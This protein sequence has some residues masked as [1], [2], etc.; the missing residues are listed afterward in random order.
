MQKKIDS[1]F[2]FARKSGSL[3]SGAGTCEVLAGKG[4]LKLLI[5]TEDT[6]EGSCRKMQRLARANNIPYRIYG[7][8]DHLSHV[9]GMSGR[10]VFAVTDQGFADVITK[11]I[12]AEQKY[13]KEVF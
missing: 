10:N 6:A 7:N 2:G 13:E 12:D 11:E 3:V 5:I 1:Y 8:S 9:T 4:R